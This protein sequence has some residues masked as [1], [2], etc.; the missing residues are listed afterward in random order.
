MATPRKHI[1]DQE[2][3]GFYHVTN[4]CV[5]RTFLCGVDEVTGTDFSHRK[6]WLER[7]MFELCETFAVEIYAYA[8]MDNHYHIVLSVDPKAPE[9]WTDEAVADRWIKAYPGQLDLPENRKLRE[10]KK[11]AI[12]ADKD[13]LTTYRK[14]LGN[15]SWYMGRLN[16]P[17]A[18]Q[19]NLED[20]CT[21]RFWEGRYSAQALL[22]EAALVSCMAYVDLNPIRANMAQ[23]LEDSKH[24]SIHCR[25]DNIKQQE[26]IKVQAYLDSPTLPVL[27][28]DKSLPLALSL[29]DYILLVEWTGKSIV[30]PH[31]HAI[32]QGVASI[33]ECLNLQQNHWLKHIQQFNENYCHVVGHFQQI[34]NK[35]TSLKQRCMRGISAAK[36]VYRDSK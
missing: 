17:L 22:D 25:L 31:K 23:K 2:N 19:S 34:K 13:R 21:G 32:P 11:Q 15:L 3:F 29:K 24:T 7:R 14:R 36:L 8:V 35:A 6:D 10:L 20:G 28:S 27:S 30:Y 16:E 9:T 5:R 18:R 33:L 12:M 4:R 1:V 26:P